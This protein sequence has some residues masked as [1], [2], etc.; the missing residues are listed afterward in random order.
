M[1]TLDN[2]LKYAG[3]GWSVFPVDPG[4]K[5]PLVRWREESSSD[6]EQVTEMWS[7]M[8]NANIGIDCGKSGL[9]VID[10]DDIAAIK[11]LS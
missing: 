9:V 5:K 2:A 6:P 8:P 3:Y 1:E 7:L 10:V 4:G 11:N